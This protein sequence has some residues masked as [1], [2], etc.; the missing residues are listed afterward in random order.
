MTK[1]LT[2]NSPK[3]PK[4]S[5]LKC[6]PEDE[7]LFSSKIISKSWIMLTKVKE[8]QSKK[9]IPPIRHIS[10]LSNISRLQL[11]RPRHIEQEQEPKQWW[12]SPNKYTSGIAYTYGN[13][14]REIH[15]MNLAHQAFQSKMFPGYSVKNAESPRPNSDSTYQITD[16]DLEEKHIVGSQSLAESSMLHVI[17]LN[18]YY[19]IKWTH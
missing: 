18:L 4:L 5:L 7:K 16:P 3:S 15:M 14:L 17:F 10:N 2:P 9:S 13:C 11:E 19:S 8:N 1:F 12:Q 6:I